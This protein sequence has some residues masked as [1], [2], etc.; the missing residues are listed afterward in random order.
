MPAKANLEPSFLLLKALILTGIVT[1]TRGQSNTIEPPNPPRCVRITSSVCSKLGWN[2]TLP[3]FLGMNVQTSVDKELEPYLT[4]YTTGC[5]NAMLHFICAVYYPPCFTQGAQTLTYNPCRQLCE[6][7]RCTCEDDVR[8]LGAVW[9][10]Q[11]DCNQFTF[12]SGDGST[13][14]LGGSEAF[15][16]LLQLELPRVEG[17]LYPTHIQKCGGGSGTPPISVTNSS[18]SN[19]STQPTSP[20]KTTATPIIAECIV[21]E[22]DVVNKLSSYDRYYLG[23]RQYCGMPCEGEGLYGSE[24]HALHTVI[25]LLILI[26][27]SV[28]AILSLFTIATFLIDRNRFP[29]PERPM[30][31]LSISYFMLS[32]TF[33]VAS[34][35]KLAGFNMACSAKIGF[36]F[37][38][39]PHFTDEF[40]SVEGNT[41]TALGVFLYYATMAALVWWVVLAMTWFL[42]AMLKW[43]E[44]AVSKFWLLYHVLAWGI[45]ILQLIVLLS[46]H[47]FDGEA[48]GGI[49]YIGHFDVVANAIGV[50]VASCVYVAIATTLTILSLVAM[51]L[52]RKQVPKT[53]SEQRSKV[54]RL[55]LRLAVFFVAIFLPNLILLLLHIYQLSAQEGWEVLALCEGARSDTPPSRPTECSGVTSAQNPG[56]TF[57]FVRYLMWVGLCS[58]SFILVVSKKTVYSWKRFVLDICGGLRRKPSEQP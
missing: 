55:T 32:V 26:L 5:S 12:G 7:V 20:T 11:L 36:V 50:L 14:F 37:Q 8:E 57:T 31:Y 46:V 15:D 18:R 27:S 51:M 30:V 21:S 56:I 10:T 35:S 28:G 41:C 38:E 17:Q 48:L 19:S 24:A 34:T 25:P 40:S 9:P 3:N 54:T 45:P 47:K 4:L 42:A 39:L 22:L 49:C 16:T 1:H 6:Y 43:A 52:I 2:G 58:S 53:D 13:C 23:D 29:Y 44:E 33:L